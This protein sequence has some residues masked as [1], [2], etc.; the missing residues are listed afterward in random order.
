MAYCA[1]EML[2]DHPSGMCKV[3]TTKADVWSA[4]LIVWESWTQKPWLEDKNLSNLRKAVLARTV[5]DMST[6]P[7]FLEAIMRYGL[8]FND[9][10]R[11]EA[12]V[13]GVRSCVSVCVCDKH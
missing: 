6:V 10:K 9:R 3:F 13:S 4:M 1:P 2:Q 12:S 7:P 5:P 11:P 8:Q